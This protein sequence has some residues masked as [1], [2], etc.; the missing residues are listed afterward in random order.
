MI[1]TKYRIA[2]IGSRNYN[3]KEEIYKYLD[4]KI[5]KIGCLVSGGCPSGADSIAQQYAKDKGL[6]ITIH[7]PDWSKG[8]GAGFARNR[9]I[10]EDCQVLIAFWKDKSKGTEHTI[11]LAKKLNKKVVIFEI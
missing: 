3:N 1:N 11:N 6:S 2:V 7:Y 5:D 4:S 8:K 10:V 9:K